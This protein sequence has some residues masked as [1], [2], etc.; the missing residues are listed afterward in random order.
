LVAKKDISVGLHLIC[1][2]QRNNFINIYKLS[3]LSHNPTLQ[4]VTKIIFIEASV[5]AVGILSFA[6]RL[7]LGVGICIGNILD[8]EW[9]QNLLCIPYSTENVFRKNHRN[10]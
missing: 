10:I 6:N 7:G 4:S 8:T 5:I 3:T 9:G 2:N 1:R